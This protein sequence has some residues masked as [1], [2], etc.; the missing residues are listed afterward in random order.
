MDNVEDVYPLA[1]MQEMMLLRS[2]SRRRVDTL[3]NQFRFEL[4]GPLNSEIFRAGWQ[5]LTER[6]SSGRA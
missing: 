6:C 5:T 4:R 1:P 2:L 3:F